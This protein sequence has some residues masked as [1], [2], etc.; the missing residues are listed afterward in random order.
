MR[1][2]G[3]GNSSGGPAVASPRRRV[4]EGLSAPVGLAECGRSDAMSITQTV[5][6]LVARLCLLGA[7]GSALHAQLLLTVDDSNPAAVTFTA[8]GTASGA[9]ASGSGPFPIR[10]ET[11]LTAGSASSSPTATSS[12][13]QATATGDLLNTADWD[14]NGVGVTTL[15]LRNGSSSKESFSTSSPAFSGT[16]TFDLSGI[17]AFLPAGGTTGSI[18]T[19][20]GALIGTYSV[21]AVPEPVAGGLVGGLACLAFAAAERRKRLGLLRQRSERAADCTVSLIPLR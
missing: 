11:F 4:S 20:T 15:G 12:T 6:R 13:L 10:L 8:T 2:R 17:S 21:T 7:C 16:A 14:S 18:Q 3:K 5:R 9:T 19:S 1:P